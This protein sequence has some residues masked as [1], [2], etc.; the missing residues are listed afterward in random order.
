[1]SR[2]SRQDC[3]AVGVVEPANLSEEIAGTSAKPI[4]TGAIGLFVKKIRSIKLPI[5]P[6]NAAYGNIDGGNTLTNSGNDKIATMAT[7]V[8]KITVLLET[9]RDQTDTGFI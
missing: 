8:L 5:E 3:Y 7:M 6:P 9:M 4:V 1:M 2:L